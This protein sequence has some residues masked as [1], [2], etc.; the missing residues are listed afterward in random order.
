MQIKIKDIILT[1]INGSAI[2]KDID[3][4]V[5]FSEKYTNY[6][7]NSRL[8]LMNPDENGSPKLYKEGFGSWKT[9]SL[10][11]GTAVHELFLQPDLFSLH[12][13]MSKPSAKVGDIID[14]II[15]YR[16]DGLSIYDSIQRGVIDIDYYGGKMTDKR[17]RNI[18]TV[19]LEYY[20][21]A[22]NNPD[23]IIMLSKDNYIK[24]SECLKS[25][26]KTFIKNIINPKDEYGDNVGLS[27]N[28]DALF[29]NI[30]VSYEGKS[31]VLKL[32]MKADNWTIDFEKKTICLNDLKTTNSML[33]HFMESSF[34]TYHYYR[35]IGFYLYVL[36]QHCKQEY[37]ITD[38][39][40][41]TVGANIIA[42]RNSGNYT[43]AV[44]PI[45]I[46]LINKGKIEF[47]KLLRMVGYCEMFGYS[48]DLI[49]E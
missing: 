33:N 36:L 8:K 7:S 3:D 17:T 14:K 47:C 19:G 48:D 38:I 29:F 32:K 12:N 10:I 27:F 30:G 41:W 42:V 4:S 40:E 31:T 5:Y 18:I 16:K 34:N 24:C 9:N 39:S 2:K 45:N 26:N 21:I 44:Y 28:E 43:S 37:N 25:L 1:P 20:F 11:L 23:N 13:N 49:F 22:K 35:Q 46:E 6:V 15:K